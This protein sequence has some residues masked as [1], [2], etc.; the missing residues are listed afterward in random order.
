M[1][2]KKIQKNVS[3]KFRVPS[4]VALMIKEVKA[5]CES[6]AWGFSLG[7]EVARMIAKTCKQALEEIDA[8]KKR[9]EK[10]EKE[11]QQSTSPAT[12]RQFKLPL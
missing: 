10:K 1:I 5:E 8:E 9:R 3:V 4:D 6:L 12:P 7:E 11:S 2:I